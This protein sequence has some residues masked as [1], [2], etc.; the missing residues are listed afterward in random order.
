[1][2][3]IIQRVK[4]N[5][6]YDEGDLKSKRGFW[7]RVLDVYTADSHFSTPTGMVTSQVLNAKGGLGFELDIPGKIA[8]YTTFGLNNKRISRLMSSGNYVATKVRDMKMHRRKVNDM[9]LRIMYLYP[10]SSG[11]NAG[12][13]FFKDRLDNQEAFLELLKNISEYT[14]YEALAVP[15][16][17]YKLDEQ[18][19]VLENAANALESGRLK[20]IIPVIDLR[21]KVGALKAFINEILDKFF[22]TGLIKAVGIRNS[23]AV[24]TLPADTVTSQLLSN[25]E[26][27]TMVFGIKKTTN[28]FSG[29]HSQSLRFGDAFAN[30]VRPF[31]KSNSQNTNEYEPEFLDTQDLRMAKMLLDPN[32]GHF[33]AVL[34]EELKNMFDQDYSLAET[35]IQKFIDNP[36]NK[37]VVVSVSDISKIHSWIY[38]ELEFY[39][40]REKLLNGSYNEYIRERREIYESLPLIFR[41]I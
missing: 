29:I 1:M 23:S 11:E 34:K 5:E 7:P 8:L 36:T 4:F 17:S 13:N 6:K 27:L 33:Y 28:G 18:I 32:G 24:E 20:E 38:G 31:F 15:V 37:E 16:L 19:R 2:G 39:K 9:P 26:I 35:I 40:L 10:S 22:E 30:L 3:A 21:E 12:I 14:S 41:S 25:K